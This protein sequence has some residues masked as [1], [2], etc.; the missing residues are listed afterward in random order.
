MPNPIAPSLFADPRVAQAKE[1][2]RAALADHQKQITGI[3]PPDPERKIAYEEML[4]HFGMA[5]GGPLFFPYLGSGLGKGAL[6]ELADGS[7]KYDMISGI[8]VHY[9]GHSHPMLLDAGV[10]AAIRDTVMQGNLQQNVESVPLA[11]TLVEM[12]NRAGE[13]AR[14]AHCF[15][16]TSGAMANENALKIAF[17]KHQPASRVLAFS[18]GFAGR[19]MALSQITDKAAYRVGLPKVLDVDY[20]PFYNADQ[21]EHSTAAAVN[22][23]KEHLQRYP[24]QH[25]C[26]WMELIQGEGGFYAGTREFFLPI[27]ELLKENGVAVWFDEIQTF[28]RTSQ[29]FAFQHFGLDAHVDLLTV[30]KITQVCAT[31][32]TDAYIPKPGLVSQTFTASTSAILAAQ[33][34]LDV[35]KSGGFF[36]ESGRIMQVRQRVMSH[37]DRIRGEHPEWLKGP[38]GAGAMIAFT[39][40]DGSEAT[41]KK[42]LTDLFD[43]GV[44]AFV[45]GAN[46]ARLRF[47]PPVGVVTDGDIDAALGILE[48]ALAAHA[49]R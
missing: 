4:Q 19:S 10:D 22:R 41:A 14:I 1:L 37:L 31:L 44:V 32:F 47:L 33:A 12:A 23:I 43:A 7:V 13:A 24:K 9:F 27:I 21:P 5:R 49:G 25:A 2:L 20:V 3:R 39:P 6:V 17:Q 40:F 46:P 38:F 16:T 29:P 28:A 30:G 34:I 18:H 11:K 36:G 35:L 42:L 15:L 48:R 45:C 26:M 8:G